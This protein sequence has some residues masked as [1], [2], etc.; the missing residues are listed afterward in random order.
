MS[1]FTIVVIDDDKDIGALMKKALENH[2]PYTVYVTDNGV[3]GEQFC[4][5][6]R[7]ALIFLDYV[8]PGTKGDQV[9]D[10]LRSRPETCEIPIVLMS[11]LGE[12]DYIDVKE[13]WKWVPNTKVVHERGEIPEALK[14]K[15][16]A[17]EVAAE[18][19][20]RVYLHK[21]FSRETLLEV[22]AAI[23]TPPEQVEEDI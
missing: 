19:G 4:V 10:F 13:Q 3:E 22:A 16:D 6:H 5:Q 17:E 8:M 7:P 23:L 20:V 18:L 11:G 1:S 9:I 14:W 21:P 2:G 12:M 15:H